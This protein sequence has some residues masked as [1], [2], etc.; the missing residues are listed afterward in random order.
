MLFIII[1]TLSHR[2]EWIKNMTKVLIVDDA[3]FIRLAI[4]TMLERYDFEVIGEAENGEIGI[5][6]YLALQPDLVIMDIT[7]PILGGIE[8]LKAILKLDSK[9]KVVMLSAMGQESVVREAV[10]SGAKTFIVKP[11][12]EDHVI[13]TL[14][15]IA[16]M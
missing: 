7:M 2:K 13:K 15:K 9:A 3:S 10:I 11:F 16:A 14:T 5:Q 12:K 1:Y 8:S 4:K 6:K